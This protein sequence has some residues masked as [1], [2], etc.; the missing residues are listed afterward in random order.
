M[1]LKVYSTIEHYIPPSKTP[2]L[3]SRGFFVLY[4][5]SLTNRRISVEYIVIGSN[6]TIDTLT[7]LGLVFIAPVG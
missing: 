4:T 1:P 3:D 5:V 7:R 6:I 2:A